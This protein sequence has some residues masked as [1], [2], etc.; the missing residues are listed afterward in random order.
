MGWSPAPAQG[1]A[2]TGASARTARNLIFMVSD[3]MSF[4]TLSLAEIV[5]QRT[6]GRTS[7]WV[8]LFGKAGVRRSAQ[9]TS[10]ADSLVTDSSAAASAWGCGFKI[11][12]SAVNVTPDG[13]QRLPLLVHARQNGKATGVVTTARITHATPAGFYSNCPDRALEKDI[14]KDWLDRGIDLALGG[15][16]QFFT[17]DLLAPHQDLRIMRTGAELASGVGS[18]GSPDQRWLG[19][20]A[21]GHVPF[22]LDRTASLSTKDPMDVPTLAAMSRAAIQRLS[23]SSRGHKSGFVLQIE[24]GRIDH[25]AHNND[26][27]SL[28]REQLA[29]D[30]ALGVALE[31]VESR[32]D[33]LLVV[34]TDHGNANPGLTVY[35]AASFQAIDRLVEVTHSFDWIFEHLGSGT[36]DERLGR[37]PDLVERATG[38]KLKDPQQDM[39][40]RVIKGESVTPFDGLNLPTG[41]LGGILANTLGVGFVSGHH[42]ADQVELTLLGPGSE[43]FPGEI[44]NNDIHAILVETLR[45]GPGEM[46]PGMDAIARVKKPSASD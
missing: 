22:E 19:L 13:V 9:N 30:D 8:S 11:N 5:A 18:L 28:V 31:F 7:N 14:A 34:T 44:E 37:L 16:S 3:G 39:M 35:N 26:A 38:V 32:D 27:A 21:G 25:A 42:T 15:G 23:G 6:K 24:G 17:Q 45:L 29:F 40:R 33:T 4:G 2:A 36:L 10:S 1:P 43:R 41:V 20:F 12:N 46:L